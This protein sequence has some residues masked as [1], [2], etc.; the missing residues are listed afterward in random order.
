MASVTST[1]A[2][3]LPKVRAGL[4][5]LA[6]MLSSFGAFRC[7]PGGQVE[8]ADQVAD[9]A[10]AVLAAYR[11]YEGSRCARWVSPFTSG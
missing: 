3:P 11:T 4:A 6:P 10:V 2:A 1:D 7:R 9:P 5:R 8:A